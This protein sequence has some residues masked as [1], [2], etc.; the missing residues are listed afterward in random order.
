MVARLVYHVGERGALLGPVGCGPVA[1]AAVL[2]EEGLSARD[3][4]GRRG[5]YLS[6]EDLH[7]IHG[8][9]RT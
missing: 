7:L 8:G 6:E 4:G 2:L 3:L 5:G 1:G 9:C